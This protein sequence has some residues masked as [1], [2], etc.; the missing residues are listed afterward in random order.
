MS[1]KQKLL[2]KLI[3]NPENV[4]FKE[5]ELLLNYYNFINIRNT[6]S[7]RIDKNKEIIFVVPVHGKK[8]K[9]IYVKRFIEIL[10]NNFRV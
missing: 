6:G 9:S 7:H 1:R 5:L 8:V 10:R 3:N 4:F 2:L